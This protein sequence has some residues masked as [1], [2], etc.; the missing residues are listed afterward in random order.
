MPSNI[1][2]GTARRTTREF[3]S[4]LH[5]ARGSL[6]ELETH[7]LLA[8]SVGHLE[9]DEVLEIQRSIDE[10]G[11]LINGVLRGLRKRVERDQASGGERRSPPST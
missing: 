6:A 10:V 2:E 4:F 8:A 11:R 3:V 1:A 7:L 9:P 5:F